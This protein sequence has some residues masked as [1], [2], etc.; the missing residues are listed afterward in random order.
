[1]KKLL[2]LLIIVFLSTIQLFSQN[3]NTFSSEIAPAFTGTGDALGISFSN[4]FS[5]TIINNL[6][7][8]LSLE[9]QNFTNA[10]YND[11]LDYKNF[12]LNLHY[13]FNITSNLKFMLS[14]GSFYR[15]TNHISFS[16]THT[17]TDSYGDKYDI[18]STHSNKYD[19]YGYATSLGL[20]FYINEKIS[21]STKASLQNDTN[22]DITWTL[23]P[24][25][26]FHF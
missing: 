8:G 13:Q 4:E 11:A 16:Q 17:I 3:K 19:G 5:R 26:N 6:N 21:F 20:I 22:G 9:L 15:I 7:L 18:Y 14:A 12:G 23:R 25:I 10:Y 2:P 1:M 24:G